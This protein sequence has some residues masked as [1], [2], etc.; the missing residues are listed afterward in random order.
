VIKLVVF[1]IGSGDGVDDNFG[2]LIKIL[3]KE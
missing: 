2:R 3:I 1:E